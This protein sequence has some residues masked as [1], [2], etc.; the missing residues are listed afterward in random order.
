MS[1]CFG[2]TFSN[3]VYRLKIK[4]AK[5]AQL[6]FENLLK[7]NCKSKTSIEYPFSKAI[8]NNRNVCKSH[9]I[10]NLLTGLRT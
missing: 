8:F 2:E 1:S 5:I 9:I 10:E 4:D 3:F 6:P 7:T